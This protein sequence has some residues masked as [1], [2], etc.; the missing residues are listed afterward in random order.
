MIDVD[1]AREY[2]TQGFVV[3]ANLH[4]DRLGLGFHD[5]EIIAVRVS[6]TGIG[7]CR[8]GVSVFILPHKPCRVCAP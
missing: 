6:A 8:T 1:G 3:V 7:R 4:A 2:T 5:D